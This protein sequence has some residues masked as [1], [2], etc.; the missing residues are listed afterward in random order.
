VYN[1]NIPKERETMSHNES[2]K[3]TLVEYTF[4]GQRVVSAIYYLDLFKFLAEN[5]DATI[6]KK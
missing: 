5:K 1:R 3:Y 6:I 4:G 2:K